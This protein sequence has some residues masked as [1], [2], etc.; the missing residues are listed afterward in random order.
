[1]IFSTDI[2]F[3]LGYLQIKIMDS[4]VIKIDG[5]FLTGRNGPKFIWTKLDISN[6]ISSHSLWVDYLETH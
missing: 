5:Q 6:C 4:I 3:L 2:N 1:M